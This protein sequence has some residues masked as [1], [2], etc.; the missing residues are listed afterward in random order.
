[1]TW[2][3]RR[4]FVFGVPL[5]V[6][7]LGLY[8][9]WPPYLEP[10][11]SSDLGSTVVGGGSSLSSY[12]ISIRYFLEGRRRISFDSSSAPGAISRE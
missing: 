12:C 11:R 1:M 9:W 6:I 3:W 5:V 2:T 7:V 8:L 10:D 4:G